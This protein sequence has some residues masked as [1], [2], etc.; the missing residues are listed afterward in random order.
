MV[1]LNL[2]AYWTSGGPPTICTTKGNSYYEAIEWVGR[3]GGVAARWAQ[4]SQLPPISQYHVAAASFTAVRA[5]L[6]CIPLGKAFR[7]CIGTRRSGGLEDKGFAHFW[8]LLD[9]KP[10]SRGRRPTSSNTMAA[11]RCN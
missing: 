7:I 5:S 3:R 6:R 9:L 10:G 2:P 1:N 4:R 11:Y 8:W